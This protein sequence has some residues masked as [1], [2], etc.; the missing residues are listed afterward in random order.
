MAAD[1]FWATLFRPLGALVFL[2]VAAIIAWPIKRTLTKY[3]GGSSFVKLLL[4]RNIQKNHPILVTI[5]ALL[6]IILIVAIV[7]ISGVS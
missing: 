6:P 4:D 7:I 2:F 3:G 5:L 1:S